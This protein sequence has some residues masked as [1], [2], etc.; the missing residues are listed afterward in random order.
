VEEAHR[1]LSDANLKDLALE[2]RKYIG[3]LVI[4]TADPGSLIDIMPT[5]SPL[6]IA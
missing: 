2:A 6:P 3:K 5:F 1:F 4:A